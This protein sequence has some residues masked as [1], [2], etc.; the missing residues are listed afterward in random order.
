MSRC[1]PGFRIVSVCVLMLL[2]MSAVAFA[3]G[4]HDRTQVGS[5]ISVGPGEEAGELTCFGCSVRVRGHVT[6]DVTVFG[7]S[8]SVEDQGQVDGDATAFAGGIR[9]EREVKV[10]GDVS[11]FG[12]RVRRDPSASIGGD[13]TN[14]GGAGWMILIFV[15]PLAIVGL[16]VAFIVW[17]IRRLLRPAIAA[18]V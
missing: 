7:G 2:A 9:L 12:G 1:S 16:F 14:F 8:I 17:L 10:A 18:A 6:G 13:V 5:N 3:D 15:L 4:S 11:V